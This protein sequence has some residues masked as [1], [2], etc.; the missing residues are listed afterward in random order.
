MLRT[1]LNS[2]NDTENN[3]KTSKNTC[4]LQLCMV[5]T[6]KD[7]PDL[8]QRLSMNKFLAPRPQTT[9]ISVRFNVLIYYNAQRDG[10]KTTKTLGNPK[11][12]P[13]V[14]STLL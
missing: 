12:V 11:K 10:H 4:K 2:A 6:R 3:S 1:T 13:P 7:Y 8:F 9:T 5:F 14:E